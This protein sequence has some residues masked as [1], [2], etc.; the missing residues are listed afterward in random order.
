MDG[1]M[2][3]FFDFRDKTLEDVASEIAKDEDFKAACRD[4][5]Y[6]GVRQRIN[7]V[8]QNEIVS[9]IDLVRGKHRLQEVLWQ[10]FK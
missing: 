5:F 6:E 10:A 3:L 7:A 1:V 4:I 8:N 9:V 2:K